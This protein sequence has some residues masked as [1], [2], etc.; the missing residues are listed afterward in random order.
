MDDHSLNSFWQLLITRVRT[1]VREPAA[2]FWVY[3][4]PLIMVF[5]LGTAF[6]SERMEVVAV[7]VT[8]PA[9][10]GESLSN[11]LVM[12]ALTVHEHFHVQG[13]S[14]DEAMQR[15][16][17]GKT[18]LIVTVTEDSTATVKPQFNYTFDPT[19]PGSLMARNSI[20]DVLQRTFGREDAISTA[21]NEVSQSG[22]RYIDFL[23]P[24]LIGMGLMGGGMWG[25]GFA[26]VDLRIRKLLKRF[27]ATPM[28]RTHFLGAMI[29]SRLMFTVPEVVII[30]LCSRY[31]FGV[32]VQGNVWVFGL[33]IVAGAVQFSGIGLLV[34]SRASTVETVS[35]L[36]NAVMMPMWIASGIF[37]SADRFPDAVQPIVKCL[38]L[39]TLIDALRRVMLEG[40]GIN[41]IGLSLLIILTWGFGCFGLALKL[42]RWQ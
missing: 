31:F 28:K 16:R 8:E 39:T 2:V 41:Q 19:R 15:L 18:E 3:A 14:G 37:F 5:S 40:A 33:L 11:D 34:A 21:N 22:S 10:G 42:F 30:L 20:D 17:T 24:G 36:M 29:C 23:V 9:S 25:V 27:V 7:D 13:S 12:S 35:G 1:F 4:F 38:P 32:E 6:R 26:T